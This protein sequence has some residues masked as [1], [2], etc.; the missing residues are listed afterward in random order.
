[1]KYKTTNEW[2]HFDFSEA[3]ISEIQKI[4]GY[5]QMT[6]DNVGIC[7]DNSQ[8]RDI[9]KM[10]TNGLLFQIQ[11]GVVASLTE[12]GYQVY[13]AEGLLLHQYEDHEIP[14]ESQNELLKSFMDGECSLYQ[15]EKS[16]DV[17]TFI[18]DSSNERTYVLRVTGARDIEEWDRFLNL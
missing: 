12:E 3:Y 8:N 15:V 4:N 16:E 2:E 7:P 5:F 10:R 18:I 1:M 6:L 14:P 17:Y 13:N 9:R 11:D